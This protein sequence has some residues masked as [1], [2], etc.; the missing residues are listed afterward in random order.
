MVSFDDIFK[1]NFLNN[2]TSFSMVDSCI[3]IF[4]SLILGYV[5]YLVYSRIYKGP[6][7]SRSFGLTLI[8]MTVITAMLIVAVTSNIVLSLGMVGALSIVRFRTAVKEALDISYIF[9]AIAVGII[10]GAGL[11]PLAVIGT[12]VVGLLFMLTSKS[13]LFSG[14][15]YVLLVE[16][17]ES[18]KGNIE[19]AIKSHSKK[20]I[21]KAE[22]E[23]D[24][25]VEYTYE[26]FLEKADTSVREA[27]S[28]IDGVDKV[29]LVSYSGDFM[30]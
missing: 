7:Y 21:T 25:K 19:S 29:T 30:G 20:Y 5:I 24:G 26:V 13:V 18:I 14:K 4:V 17:R 23:A 22:A 10:V 2:T 8:S 12:L 16:G 15:T 27:L 3:A 9:W 28:A 6:M 11:I 1:S